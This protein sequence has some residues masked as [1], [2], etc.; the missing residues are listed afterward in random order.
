MFQF[1]YICFCLFIYVSVCLYMFQFVKCEA[2][3]NSKKKKKSQAVKYCSQFALL[4]MEMNPRRGGVLIRPSRHPVVRPPPPCLSMIQ[5]YKVRQLWTVK[6][7]SLSSVLWN[8]GRWL[9]VN[10]CEC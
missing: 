7:V 5:I 6:P 3:F 10:N 8:E 4:E 1:V 9:L 2:I